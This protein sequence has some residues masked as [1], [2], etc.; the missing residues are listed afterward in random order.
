[1]IRILYYGGL[2]AGD[3]TY[4]SLITGTAVDTSETQYPYAGHFD[5][6]VTPTLDINF[7]LPAELYY[8]AKGQSIT[9]NNLFNSYYSTQYDEVTDKDSKVVDMYLNLNPAD[10][11]SLDF[12][13]EV[14]IAGQYYRL[15]EIT[16]YDMI[17]AGLTKCRFL[18]VKTGRQFVATTHNLNGGRGV[19]SNQRLP[20]LNLLGIGLSSGVV[21]GI[22]N[23]T[24]K[25]GLVITGDGN[26]VTGKNVQILG[27]NN[28]VINANNITLINTSGQTIS[29]DNSTY[30]DGARY[31]KASDMS[32]QAT[33]SGGTATVGLTGVSSTSIILV[34]WTGAGT[35]TGTLS[36]DAE[37]D[38]FIIN[39]TSATDTA[40]V[41]WYIPKM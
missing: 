36:V 29:D 7:G 16:D 27:G 1:M 11:Q 3:W 8:Q 38:Y 13:N 34:S 20:V 32:G 4:R 30:I 21:I 35:L 14:Y 24:K 23:S 5:D 28:N 39:S 31:V 17:N 10:I 33:L 25:G 6:P 2:K 12:R 18:K 37:P 15:V 22:N 19:F 41:N 26:A 9:D 40:V